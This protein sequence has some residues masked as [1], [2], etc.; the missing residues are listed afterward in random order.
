[1]PQ[2]KA[3]Q[4]P[5]STTASLAA[6]AA[7]SQPESQGQ[8]DFQEGL[9]KGPRGW[10]NDVIKWD[11]YPGG[12]FKYFLFLPLPAGMIQFDSY[13]SNGLKPPPDI[14]WGDQ[15]YLWV[16]L[17]AFPYPYHPCKVYLPT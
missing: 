14:Q 2:G 16:I 5:E 15:T 7:T 1:M 9:G 17:M 11:P 13:F 12:G 6:P 8:P 10:G 4:T 3:A